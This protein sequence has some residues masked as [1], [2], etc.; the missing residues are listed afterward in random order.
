[1]DGRR[2]LYI[3]SVLLQL[4]GPQVSWMGPEGKASYSRELHP[5]F[6]LNPFLRG[7]PLFPSLDVLPDMDDMQICVPCQGMSP[8]PPT[9][10]GEHL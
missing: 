6:A 4:T 5:L 2:E 10:I 3:D 1:M 8:G 7:A 9:R